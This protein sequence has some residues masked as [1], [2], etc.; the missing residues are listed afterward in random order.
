MRSMLAASA[1]LGLCLSG[2][3]MAAEPPP[4]TCLTSAELHG[5]I[6]YFLPT[7]IG[8]VASGCSAHLPETSYLR[9]GMGTL[10]DSLAEGREAAWP[11][12]R[13]AFFK[14]SNVEEA[15]ELARLSDK[16][17]RPLVD[18]ML[19]QKLSIPVTGPMCGEV[20]DITEALAPL[21]AGQTVHLLAAIFS[22]VARNDKKLPSCPRAAG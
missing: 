5:M 15:K 14:F 22:A 16:A 17:I 10:R 1:A 9:S 4:R 7:V 6:A 20:N 12:A 11:A 8:E 21:T 2:P 18:E 19:A 13:A 3:A